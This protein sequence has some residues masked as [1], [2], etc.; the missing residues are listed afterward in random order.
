MFVFDL[1]VIGV[2]VVLLVGDV[3][4]C[5]LFCKLV[6]CECVEYVV[7]WYGGYV[8]CCVKVWYGGFCVCIYVYVWGVVFVV[9][10]D[11]WDVYFYYLCVVIGVVFCMEV[12]MVGVFVGV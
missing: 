8:V 6:I 10:V 1:F 5:V 3:V 9:E 12:V 2:D 4:C 7:V 11:F